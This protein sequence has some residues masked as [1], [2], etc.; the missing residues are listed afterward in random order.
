MSR[1]KPKKEQNSKIWRKLFLFF[2]KNCKR[3][4]WFFVS[5]FFFSKKSLWNRK[6]EKTRRKNSLLR[7]F[8]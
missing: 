7:G 5:L 1:K 3:E 6:S 4:N 2:L 8:F